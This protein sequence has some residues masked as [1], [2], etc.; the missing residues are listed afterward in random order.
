MPLLEPVG[1][2]SSASPSSPS[3]VSTTRFTPFTGSTLTSGSAVAAVA[4]GLRRS[5]LRAS[6]SSTRSASASSA[7]PLS[8]AHASPDVTASMRRAPPPTEPS[9]RIATSRSPPS[10]G[11]GCRRR[12][13][14]SSRAPRRPGRRR[15][16]SRR[17]GPLHRG[18]APRQASSRTCAQGHPRRRAVDALL[19]CVALL[20]GQLRGVGEV[21]PKLVRPNR[22]PRLGHVLT[23]HLAQR[24]L[25]EVRRRVVGHRR[26]PDDPGHDGA[27]AVTRRKA[28]A[29]ED[30]RLFSAEPVRIDELRPYRRVPVELD[31]ALSVTWPPPAG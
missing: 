5:S 29:A 30:E 7:R 28:L 17:R 26:E 10:C 23:E 8:A 18:C 1:Q 16:T 22:R 3:I 2:L 11:R 31:E 21:E 9:P 15:R 6:S 14:C 25:E 19:D 27:H 20:A 4:V 13:R 24:G 12:A